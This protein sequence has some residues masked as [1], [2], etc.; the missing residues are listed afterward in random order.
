MKN[1]GGQLEYMF[2]VYVT[3]NT[4]PFILRKFCRLP[5]LIGIPAHASTTLSLQN[6]VVYPC[7][8]V[9]RGEGWKISMGVNDYEIAFLD[10]TEKDFLW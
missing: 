9:K 6:R 1:D 3:D 7:G 8:L 2:G 5:L 4:H 10:V